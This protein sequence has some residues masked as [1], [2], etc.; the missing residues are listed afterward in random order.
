MTFAL[1]ELSKHGDSRGSLVALECNKDFPFSAERVYYIYG[2]HP[3][4]SR[5]FHAHYNLKQ[6]LICVVGQCTIVLDDGAKRVD[7]LL[8]T[9][10][11]G[12]LI[13]GFFWREMHNFSSDAILLVLASELYS[14]DDYIRDYSLFKQLASAS[15]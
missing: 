10:T 7:V 3:E 2:T 14:P 9:P 6:L 11:Q 13:D 15:Q 4:A 8:N 5:G 1:V 12:L